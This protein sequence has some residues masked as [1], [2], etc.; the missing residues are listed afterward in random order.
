MAVS[1]ERFLKLL[2]SMAGMFLPGLVGRGGPIVGR[3]IASRALRGGGAHEYPELTE[4]FYYPVQANVRLSNVGGVATRLPANNEGRDYNMTEKAAGVQDI[5]E[6]NRALALGT[7]G[8]LAGWW[9]GIDT[10]PRRDLGISSSAV[11]GIRINRDGTI[12]IKWIN[13]KKWYTYSG[14]KSVKDASEAVKQLLL[15][16][17]I[18]RALNRKGKFRHTDSEDK[19]GKPQPMKMGEWGQAHYNNMYGGL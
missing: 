14:G 13:G 3:G 10:K 1:M 17:S 7:E 4:P 18:G 8:N 2:P 19:L 9:P 15:S 5:V 6:H 16:E 12:G 11:D